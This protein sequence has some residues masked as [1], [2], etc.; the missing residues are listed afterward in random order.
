ML[1][2]CT[3]GM[4][5]DEAEKDDLWNYSKDAGRI[6]AERS[7]TVN[8]TI[9][10]QSF[11]A[12]IDTGAEISIMNGAV[13]DEL[14]GSKHR[15]ELVCL[16]TTGVALIGFSGARLKNIREQVV[17]N[18]ELGGE[19]FPMNFVIARNINTE[20]IIGMDMLTR[21]AVRIACQ[22]KML[23]LWVNGRE[24]EIKWD[25]N[26][27]IHERTVPVLR[28]NAHEASLLQPEHTYLGTEEVKLQNH[29]ESPSQ[30]SESQTWELREI[31]RQNAVVFSLEPGRMKSYVSRFKI[32]PHK[33]Y[34]CQ[35]YPVPQK[36]RA[37]VEREIS[38][39]LSADIIE[40]SVSPYLNPL[41]VVPK[42]EGCVRTCLDARRIN[43]IITPEREAPA[44]A[45]E[46]LQ[47][48]NGCQYFSRIDLVASYLQVPLH[49][50]S[51]QYTA[52]Q[53]GGRVYQF[54]RLPF[55]INL[56]V[57]HFMKAL[58]VSLGPK[59]MSEV[60]I[61]VDDIVIASETWEQHVRQLNGVLDRLKSEGVTV[62][63]E[64]SVFAQSQI[65]FL[66]HIVDA[67]GIRVDTDR[68]SAIANFP[69][70]KNRKQLQK[71]MGV[72]N[73]NRKFVESY[74]DIVAPLQHLLQKNTTWHWG[75]EQ[76]TAWDDIKGKLRRAP[77]LYH[78]D[79]ERDFYISCD[80]SGVALGAVLYQ[81]NDAGEH[82]PVSYASRSLGGAELNYTITEKELLALV[83]ACSK[84]RYFIHGRKVIVHTD[85]KALIYLNQYRLLH[86][87]ITRWVLALQGYELD[88]RY[89]PPNQQ[90][91]ADTLSRSPPGGAS[92]W[93][94]H[95]EFRILIVRPLKRQD[96]SAWRAR[97]LRGQQTD[98]WIG[99]TRQMLQERPAEHDIHQ[100]FQIYEQ[101][102]YRKARSGVWMLCIPAE[103][104]DEL[105]KEYHERIGHFGAAKTIA[106]IKEHCVFKNMRGKV[107]QVTRKCDV[108]QR[109][110]PNL[111]PLRGEAGAV[112]SRKKLEL[113]SVDMHGPLVSSRG[114]YRYIFVVLDVFTKYVKL[115]PLR[116][117][118]A[119][120]ITAKVMRN[121][122]REVGVPKAVLSDNATV[123]VGETW[124]K[125]MKER[126]IKIK[127]VSLYRP[128]GNPV[129]RVNKEL[130]RLLRLLARKRHASWASHLSIVERC[131]N[132]TRHEA[133]GVTPY[134][135][136]HGQ[137]PP[138]W[139]SRVVRFP[140][141]TPRSQEELCRRV[142]HRMRCAAEKRRCKRENGR[143]PDI[144]RDGD[145]VLVK[146]VHISSKVR[147]KVAKLADLYDGPY[148]V[149]RQV[150]RGAYEI[151]EIDSRRRRGIFNIDKLRRFVT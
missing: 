51:R 16:P 145:Q 48:F 86:G 67:D 27:C 117:A 107:R 75:T 46:L 130:N 149:M 110:K 33:P 1:A 138:R 65:S 47:R 92:G 42:K 31:L 113:L 101:F 18:V 6:H 45:D 14:R 136:N 118:T 13:L 22:Q 25:G 34:V 131:I 124:T 137:P 122:C 94:H 97:L 82:C 59:I 74:A 61:Y 80:A 70:P 41:V 123:F 73:Y 127:H 87:R 23:Y 140:V 12:I 85:H 62:N 55:G 105:I 111:R 72:L 129:E 32:K 79:W 88:I 76:Q 43:T 37:A 52:F 69:P 108:C 150:G 68:V 125:A 71:Y 98:P 114:G 119:R 50:D 103:A 5:L 142:L 128:V 91:V 35:A 102:L 151:G 139:I 54:K 141:R 36:L 78:P 9:C 44:P 64:K 134:E 146:K 89:A 121:Y 53:F 93:Q 144:L 115:F 40:R 112:T 63:K 21:H 30:L 7:P 20:I 57:C 77:V 60:T 24:L 15:K 104:E 8:L 29:I 19:E 56:S 100:G 49:I 120:A 132:E 95:S 90:V 2:Q 81:V 106:A 3:I 58:E 96:A 116:K 126:G 11:P 83:Y 38:K 17:V 4:K 143:D 10:G 148:V 133:T 135:L 39:L 26:P 66:G 84:F 109:T 147:K 99:E 28:I